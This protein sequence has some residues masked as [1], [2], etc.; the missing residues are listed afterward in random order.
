[1]VSK[2]PY[3]KLFKK[4]QRVSFQFFTIVKQTATKK[5]ATKHWYPN[6]HIVS[7]IKNCNEL[8]FNSSQLSNKM[9]RRKLQQSKF[10]QLSLKKQPKNCNK[11]YVKQHPQKFFRA[12]FLRGTPAQFF[13]EK[14]PKG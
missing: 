12:I 4:L 10:L 3:S 2:S 13:F 6:H 5:T 7:F 14:E 8:V 1:M 11:G 9:Q